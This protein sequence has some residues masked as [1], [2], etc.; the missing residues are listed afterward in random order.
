MD[1]LERIRTECIS[2]A[3]VVVTFL[4]VVA[5]YSAY[6][7][8]DTTCIEDNEWLCWERYP[9]NAVSLNL[10]IANSIADC[11][12][13]V[14]P[15]D[16]TGEPGIVDF[17]AQMEAISSR[18]RELEEEKMRLMI[19]KRISDYHRTVCPG[20]FVCDQDQCYCQPE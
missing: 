18:Y 19:R 6:S 4:F 12:N 11:S 7:H 2:L 1:I 14:H 17:S 20:G 3:T 10:C 16:G 13:H 9:D 15:R 8:S 5:P